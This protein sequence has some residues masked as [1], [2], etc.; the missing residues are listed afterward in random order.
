MHIIRAVYWSFDGHFYC[1]CCRFFAWGPWLAWRH[2]F[3]YS[4]FLRMRASAFPL[5]DNKLTECLPKSVKWLKTLGYVHMKL[6]RRTCVLNVHCTVTCTA[7][8]MCT[9]QFS[10]VCVDVH[11]WAIKL[12]HCT[13]A[14]CV[15]GALGARWQLVFIDVPA[16]ACTALDQR[17]GVYGRRSWVPVCGRYTRSF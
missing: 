2:C 17:A 5:Y 3:L 10:P 12:L 7:T 16:C 9:L 13:C 6:R 14:R 15:T 1:M 8:Y 11:I 4:H